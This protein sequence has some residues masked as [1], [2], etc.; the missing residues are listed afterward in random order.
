MAVSSFH[1]PAGLRVCHHQT[2]PHLLA[3]DGDPKS[4]ISILEFNPG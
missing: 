4:L 1:K 3:I 2:S